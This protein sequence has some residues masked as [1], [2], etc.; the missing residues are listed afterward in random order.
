MALIDH[1]NEFAARFGGPMVR[2]GLPL[3]SVVRLA[4]S[5]RGS[6]LTQRSLNLASLE[7]PLRRAF[8]R[9]GVKAVALVIN[10]PGG[11]AVQSEQI[12]ERIRQLSE[13]HCQSKLA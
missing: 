6:G 11:S 3:V 13:G 9:R 1:F 10:S 7:V 2:G 4:G 8:G 12:A 5:I